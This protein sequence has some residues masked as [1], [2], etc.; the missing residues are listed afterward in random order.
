[1]AQ[2]TP[3]SVAPVEPSSR[4]GSNNDYS[5]GQ[6]KI[7]ARLTLCFAAFALL[8]VGGATVAVWQ[9]ERVEA[10][11]HHSYETDQRSLP[12][13]RVHLDVLTFGETLAGLADAQDRREFAKQAS[14]L[15]DAF[16]KDT[17][18]AQQAFSLAPGADHDATILTRLETVRN[19]LPAQTDYMLELVKAEDWQAVRL[20]LAN[21]VQFLVQSSSWLMEDVDRRSRKKERR[22]WRV[23]RE[24]GASFS[25]CCRLLLC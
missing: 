1:M 23:R 9:F 21:E 19:G 20:R 15:R 17:A 8:V 12:I 25:S 18:Q 14:F 3:A 24:R 10:L 5:Y 11:A 13:M 2:D 6:L 16:L 4:A 22:Q 7:G